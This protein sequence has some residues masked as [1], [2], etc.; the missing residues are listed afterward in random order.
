MWELDH[1]KAEHWRIDAFELWCWRRLLRVPWTARLNH[2]ILREIS[3]EYSFEELMVKLK[4]QYFGHLIRRADSRP[5]CWEWLKAGAD[6][7]DRGWDGWMVS[8]TQWTLV[9]ANSGRYWRTEKPGVR[10]SMRSHRVRHDLVTEQQQ[11]DAEEQKFKWY[12]NGQENK[13]KAYLD[14][15]KQKWQRRKQQKLRKR[16][17]S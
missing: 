8:L 13:K 5:W 1:R 2:S 6:G 16:S 9:W 4:L 10:Q 14:F 3:P 15:S 7:N 12:H 17:L 11:Q